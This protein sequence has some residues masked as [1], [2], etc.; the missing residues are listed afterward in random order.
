MKLLYKR[1]QWLN[2]SRRTSERR[3]K[4]KQSG[5]RRRRKQLRFIVLP[6]LPLEA[7]ETFSLSE[8]YTAV[9]SYFEEIADALSRGRDV[10][11]DMRTVKELN[12][13][14]ILYMSSMLYEFNTNRRTYRGTF[15]GTAPNIPE[16]REMFTESG[17][18]DWVKSSIKTQQ[19]IITN[20]QFVR[21]KHG[22]NVNPALAQGVK[23][24]AAAKLGNLD[25]LFG[26]SLYKT[27]IECM[28]NSNNHAFRTKNK[29]R[30]WLIARFNKKANNVR[31]VFLDRGLTIPYTVRK[32]VSEQIEDAIPEVVKRLVPIV[33]SQD[34]ELV[35]SALE[36]DFRTTT[37]QANRGKGLPMILDAAKS[38]HIVNL[39]VFSRAGLYTSGGG[40]APL[41]I[42][43]PGT[44]L[45]WD[46]V[47]G[48][49]TLKEAS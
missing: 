27:L 30:W 10:L 21:L 8:N 29:G 19:T 47:S 38:G 20:S 7:P 4:V 43:F 14:A 23:Q 34:A 41:P 37:R 5:G 48:S 22:Q 35:L 46:F 44:M 36:G 12:P 3:L 1:W 16:L 25:P 6:P 24:F 31:F 9:V 32:S 49:E 45:S 11:I 15:H 33:S 17:F 2:H 42:S 28:A 40:P 18:Y 13:D 26:K 39:R